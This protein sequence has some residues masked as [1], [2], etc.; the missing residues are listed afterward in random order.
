MGLGFLI[1]IAGHL[2]KSPAVVG[3]GIFVI[4]VATLLLPLGVHLSGD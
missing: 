2:Y 3:L 4:F 1:G